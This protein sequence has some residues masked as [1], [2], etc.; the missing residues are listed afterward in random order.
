MLRLR[1]N[2]N[3]D[4]V[5]YADRR[6][7]GRR[8]ADRLA[9]YRGRNALILGIPRGGVPVAD[10]I[11][12]GLAAEIDVVVARKVGAPSQP[13]LAI[14]AV[15]S[16]GGRFFNEA[17]IQEL[18]VSDDYLTRAVAREVAEARRRE[19]AFRAGRP[20]S[21]I[22]NRIVIVVDD[23]LATGATMRAAV[24][25]IRTRYPAKLVVAV[26]VG[27]E[28]GIA[29]LSEEVDEIISLDRPEPFY[30]VGPYYADFAPVKDAEVK[31]ILRD[32]W[33]RPA[34][35]AGPADKPD[36]AVSGKTA[37]KRL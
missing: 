12:R 13:E 23:G 37:P 20:V 30:A 27:S 22:K 3:E 32:A 36:P 2:D 26:P 19:S 28:Q 31:R 24:R 25:S 16:N 33:A 6:T 21:P 7:A 18:E 5:L 34:H 9:V 15:T 11:A 14:G 35:G 4:R 10:E 8:L 17:L 29:G 1:R